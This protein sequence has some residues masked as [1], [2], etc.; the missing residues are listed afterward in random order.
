LLGPT[1]PDLAVIGCDQIAVRSRS[2]H[3]GLTR[4]RVFLR[5]ARAQLDRSDAAFRLR[6]EPALRGLEL[7]ASGVVSDRPR[8]C[9]GRRSGIHRLVERRLN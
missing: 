7:A 8:V 1:L 9:G 3:I 2:S 6:F 5:W 4:A